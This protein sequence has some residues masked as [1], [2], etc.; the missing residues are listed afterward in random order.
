MTL[1]LFEAVQG[2]TT[3]YTPGLGHTPSQGGTYAYQRYIP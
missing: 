1:P 2:G 3:Q